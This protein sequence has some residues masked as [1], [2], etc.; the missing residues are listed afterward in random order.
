M[1]EA[2]AAVASWAVAAFETAAAIYTA[3]GPIGQAVVQTA[4]LAGAQMAIAHNTKPRDHGQLIDLQL[5]PNAPRRL[6]IGRRCNG[7]ILVDWFVSGTGTPNNRTL[8]IVV[9]LSQG[10]CGDLKGVYADGRYMTP[11]SFPHGTEVV[12]PDFRSGGDRLWV[13][14]YD[15][16]PGQTADASLVALGQGWTSACKMTGVAYAVVRYQWDSDNMRTPV[17]LVFDME[18]AYLYDRRLDTTAGGDGSHRL[19]DDTTW[20]YSTNPRVAMDHYMLGR[21]LNSVRV[22]GMGVPAEVIP[23]DRF[24]AE[25]N[26][27][28]EDVDTSDD[29]TQKRYA[30][31]G[32]L[33]SD[34]E[35]GEAIRRM[36]KC[37][38]AQ[39]N[40]FGGRYGLVGPEGSTPVME[41]D[42][43]DVLVGTREIYTP[44]RTWTSNVGGVEGRFS[45]PQQMNRDV[46][47]PRVT[48]GDWD[49][50]D[51]GETRYITHDLDMEID[52]ERAQRLAWLKAKHE[53]RHA[54]LV[55][56][57]SPKAVELE[58][59]DCFVRTGPDW[60]EDGKLF[61]VLD[62]V[63][64][65][66]ALAC[67]ITSQEVDPSDS[68]WLDSYA[69]AGPPAP[70][71]GTAQVPAMSPP[72]LT[73]TA[74]TITGT[75]YAKPAVKVAWTTPTDVRI[76]WI[77]IEV[78]PTL[79]GTQMTRSVAIPAAVDYVI[80]EDGIV[81]GV[82]YSVR[83]RFIG[84]VI[85]SVW[86][87]TV[88]VDGLSPPTF[89]GYTFAEIVADLDSN[90][91]TTAAEI[92]RGAAWRASN[93]ALLWLG[94]TQ[95]RT[96]VE[97]TVEV[98]DGAVLDLELIGTRNEAGTAWVMNAD[99]V[100]PAGEGVGSVAISLEAL[101]TEHDQ[102]TSD[103]VF[104]LESI[105][106]VYAQATLTTNV[107]GYITGFKFW[108]GGSPANSGFIIISDN[109]AVMGGDL[110]D[111]VVPFSIVGTTVKMLNVEIDTLSVN[112][113][114]TNHI[115]VNQVTE[116]FVSTYTTDVTIPSNETFVEVHPDVAFE[117]V[118]T[119]LD[120]DVTLKLKR[121]N[122][123]RCTL[124]VK[125]MKDGAQV[126]IKYFADLYPLYTNVP[127]DRQMRFT[128]QSLT[129][130]E[131]DWAIEARIY[132]GNGGV[133]GW[134]CDASEIIFRDYKR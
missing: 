74:I 111:P 124:E 29:G 131:Y 48:D 49:E 24:E 122:G 100:I 13:T 4:A 1:P 115:Q 47:Y 61:K 66:V 125:L 2:V 76:R 56:A 64:D 45:D 106:G 40:D 43:L 54:I 85:R 93:E 98:V 7:G 70:T 90:A 81:D 5:V 37:M 123:D 65:P 129:P 68:A 99:T 104:L 28:D 58:K 118:G 119:R 87:S 103:L 18:G 39:A 41:L 132:D 82:E 108:N 33:Y 101:R 57:Y 107:N 133:S 62:N 105:G 20:A 59:G 31:N 120:F 38:A 109:F 73:A 3:I 91:E 89:G 80:F 26:L 16:R 112:T 22:F 72:S 88:T 96:V 113:I 95:L 102:N 35:Y 134:T 23:Y 78:V 30:C 11:T 67:V 42:D 130:A 92:L 69:V 86:S 46:D 14:Y 94:G 36:A 114:V 17:P 32:F 19:N 9:A 21:Y 77:Y 44:K 75:T 116:D 84:D 63:Y 27:C 51:G 121:N 50:E 110:E 15:G 52:A 55:G 71:E 97:D 60:G 25:A 83:A 34:E 128:Q 127:V 117:N 79:G 53:R 126:D 8:Q 10:R 6:Q 12:I